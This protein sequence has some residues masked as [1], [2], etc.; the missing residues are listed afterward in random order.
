MKPADLAKALIA[1]AAAYLPGDE[2]LDLPSVRDIILTL[3]EDPLGKNAL[4]AE[5]SKV[6]DQATNNL[7][8]SL[9]RRVAADLERDAR[10]NA[11]RVSSVIQP[12][13]AASIA[14]LAGN[15]VGAAA[16]TLPLIWALPAGVVLLGA[17]IISSIV[18]SKTSGIESDLKRKA[19]L[20][21]AL[22]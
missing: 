17:A 8:K 4:D 9:I 7:V 2:E 18:R 10:V 3:A 11:N 13:Q 15:I 20:A 5:M 19:E 21:K 16:G 1:H 6:N 12:W 22:L 14:M